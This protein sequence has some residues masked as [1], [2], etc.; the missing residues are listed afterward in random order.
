MKRQQQQEQQQRVMQQIPFGFAHQQ[1]GNLDLTIQQ[2]K[3]QNKMTAD[4]LN[5]YR[6]TIDTMKKE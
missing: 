2:L 5:N 6:A 3:N 4:Q 1:Y